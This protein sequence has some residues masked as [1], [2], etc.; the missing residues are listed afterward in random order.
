MSSVHPA[1]DEPDLPA[2]ASERA[3]VAHL[4]H[5]VDEVAEEGGTAGR[6]GADNGVGG[7]VVEEL[8]VGVKESLPGEEI[9]EVGV[10]E[11]ILSPHV[12]RRQVG[13]AA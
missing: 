4:D 6:V 1:A 2:G 10:V 11:G 13:V 7:A 12:Q 5:G 3:D 9:G 8:L